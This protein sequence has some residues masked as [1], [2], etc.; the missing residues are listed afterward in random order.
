[1][2]DTEQIYKKM[3][4]NAYSS[5]SYARLSN[6][7]ELIDRSFSL[8]DIFFPTKFTTAENYENYSFLTAPEQKEKEDSIIVAEANKELIKEILELTGYRE[9]NEEDSGKTYSVQNAGLIESILE[10]IDEMISTYT[11]KEYV[12]SISLSKKK[13]F[14]NEELIEIIINFIDNE[15]DKGIQN[16]EKGRKD[17][18][19]RMIL[20]KPGCGKSTYIRRM[21]LAYATNEYEFIQKNNWK[22]DLFPVIIQLKALSIFVNEKK[23]IEDYI[24]NDFVDF[25]Y[26]ACCHEIREFSEQIDG[27]IFKNIIREKIKDGSLCILVDSFDEIDEQNRYCFIKKFREF[28]CQNE[29]VN[30]YICSREGSFDLQKNEKKGRVTEELC[31]IP[32]LKYQTVRDLS[33]SD[34][35][36]FVNNWFNVVFP[37]DIKNEIKIQKIIKTLC[38]S[39]I[40]YIDEIKKVPLYL[41][42]ILCLA[43]NTGDIPRSKD[44]LLAKFIELCLNS[45]I[46]EYNEYDNL[47]KQLSYLAYKMSVLGKKRIS[48]SDVREIFKECHRELSGEFRPELPLM[49]IDHYIDRVLLQCNRGD[50]F[51]VCITIQGEDIYQFVHLQ[52][53]EYFTAYAINKLYCPGVTRR[54][55]PLDIIEPY[56]GNRGWKEILIMVISMEK[57]RWGAEEYVE[58]ILEL[59]KKEED[60]YYYSN[61][62]FE[63]ATN[64]ENLS[65]EMRSSVYEAL[66]IEH[67]TDKQIRSICEGVEN[68]TLSSEFLCYIRNRFEKSLTSENIEFVF[69]NATV[70]IE[71]SIVE[72]VSPFSSAIRMFFSS[73]DGDRIL[74]LYMISV[75]AWC[76]YCDINITAIDYPFD[77]NVEV[78]ERILTFIESDNILLIE[79]ACV[80]IK[81]M[82]IAGYLA[83]RIE[84]W[85]KILEVCVKN[86]SDEKKQKHIRK[87]ISVVPISYLTIA[88]LKEAIYE[89]YGSKLVDDADSLIEKNKMDDYV[90]S[91]AECILMHRWT[92][93]ENE[94]LDQILIIQAKLSVEKNLDD[95][96]KIRMRQIVQQTSKMAN[97]ISEAFMYYSQGKYN[98]SKMIFMLAW[99]EQI[100]VKTNLAYMLRR[101]EIESVFHDG[102]EYSVDE[103]LESGIASNDATAIMNKALLISLRNNIMEYPI[104]MDYLR[105][106]KDSTDLEI[107]LSWWRDRANMGEKE[108]CLVLL[109]LLDLGVISEES[110][111]YERNELLTMIKDYVKNVV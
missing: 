14:S 106:K 58:K 47:V 1:M 29:L 31:R 33:D 3:I 83:E 73:D 105:T 5:L 23:S 63:I 72:T 68:S 66:F 100:D 24:G 45:S 17:V 103:L 7:G 25:L 61:I 50:V 26:K 89:S 60:N 91:F 99:D 77:A 82:V 70:L 55:I 90:F 10:D 108:G 104:G 71:Q 6:P 49:D 98:C 87:I 9:C 56:L 93:L 12:S 96:T 62:L 97:P 57:Q 41:S 18:C 111:G 74:G 78:I 15:L 35:I 81:D 30:V 46:S 38:Y 95:A 102:H 37:N 80:A 43:R 13:V 75:I 48:A 94:L 76:K 42:N 28:L 39:K 21:A 69:V 44:D 101:K 51:K 40:Q 2:Y 92:Y 59:Y 53:Q 36:S 19:R 34:I 110:T 86:L 64:N 85:E 20:G 4:A 8:Q 67:I 11:S 107:T 22:A 65:K 109:W 88:I 84:L 79:A 27:K 52:M 54:T 32:F 16:A